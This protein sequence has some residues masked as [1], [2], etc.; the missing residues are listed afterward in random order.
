MSEDTKTVWLHGVPGYSRGPSKAGCGT[1][2]DMGTNTG[3][4]QDWLDGQTGCGNSEACRQ[5]IKLGGQAR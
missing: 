5:K 1:V 4:N 2:T 3:S